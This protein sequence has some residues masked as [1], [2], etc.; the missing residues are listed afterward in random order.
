MTFSLTNFCPGPVHPVIW[1]QWQR[2]GYE[3]SGGHEIEA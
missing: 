3:E 1:A 2:T